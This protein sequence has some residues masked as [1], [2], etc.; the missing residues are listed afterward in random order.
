MFA[1][2]GPLLTIDS[3]FEET[4]DHVGISLVP[5]LRNLPL[6]ESSPALINLPKVLS[7]S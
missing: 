6:S 4:S 7:E 5:S 1:V 2:A 3:R